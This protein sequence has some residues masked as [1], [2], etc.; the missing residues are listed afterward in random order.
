METEIYINY[1]KYP[2]IHTKRFEVDFISSIDIK[3]HMSTKS[4]I[5]KPTE[6]QLRRMKKE[7][8]VRHRKFLT[9]DDE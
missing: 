9:M 4:M 2:L 5:T 8:I 1:T 3:N 6:R 7:I